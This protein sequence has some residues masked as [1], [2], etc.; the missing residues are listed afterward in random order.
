MIEKNIIEWLEIGDS[1]QRL[2]VYNKESMFIFQI[3]YLFSQYIH[4]S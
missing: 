2:D 4:F 3:N 1:I